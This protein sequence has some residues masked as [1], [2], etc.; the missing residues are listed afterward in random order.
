MY[1]SSSHSCISES[2]PQ[3]QSKT[4]LHLVSLLFAELIAAIE[5]IIVNFKVKMI[6]TV[7][8]VCYNMK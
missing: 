6:V 5:I 7:V 8:E 4:R 1:L 3:I 2:N